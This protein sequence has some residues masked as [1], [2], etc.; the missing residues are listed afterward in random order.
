MGIIRKNDSF[1]ANKEILQNEINTINKTGISKIKTNKEK[2]NVKNSCEMNVLPFKSHYTGLTLNL[3]S[4]NKNNEAFEFL[5]TEQQAQ[6]N[7]ELAVIPENERSKTSK[8]F[9]HHYSKANKKSKRKDSQKFTIKKSIFS[10]TPKCSAHLNKGIKDNSQNRFK[11]SITKIITESFHKIDSLNSRDKDIID[12]SSSSSISIKIK[13]KGKFKHKKYFTTNDKS[14]KINSSDSEHERIDFRSQNSQKNWS[15]IKSN[16]EN[17][18][19]KTFQMKTIDK[20]SVTAPPPPPPPSESIQPKNKILSTN[21]K[22]NI[23]PKNQK[24]HKRKNNTLDHSNIT[25]LS[26]QYCFK[27]TKITKNSDSNPKV[28]NQPP[29]P[30]P[31]CSFYIQNHSRKLKE[32]PTNLSSNNDIFHISN[33]QT[34]TNNSRTCIKQLDM[35]NL[36]ILSLNKF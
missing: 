32:K 17:K 35:V 18:D 15:K 36:D 33:K 27:N 16:E 5:K 13:N 25:L 34:K 12:L 23:K 7:D 3:K 19:V 21:T 30:P 2:I 29:P 22:T 28:P 31:L 26:T 11:N 24:K 20:L 4:K 6:K 10:V 9:S 14:L 1:K 8:K